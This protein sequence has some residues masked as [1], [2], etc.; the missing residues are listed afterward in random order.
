MYITKNN[1]NFKS[2]N[3]KKILIKHF[4]KKE[5]EDTN[6]KFSLP[7]R[8]KIC[9][10]NNNIFHTFNQYGNIYKLVIFENIYTLYIGIKINLKP[11]IKLSNLVNTYHNNCISYSYFDNNNIHKKEGF[12]ITFFQPRQYDYIIKNSKDGDYILIQEDDEYS[13][14][15]KETGLYIYNYNHNLL[16]N[17][18]Y[19]NY[20]CNHDYSDINYNDYYKSYNTVSNSNF[21]YDDFLYNYKEYEKNN[22][23]LLYE[24]DNN[25]LVYEKENNKLEYEKDNNKLLCE[26]DNNKLLY[27]KDNNELEYEK[28]DNELEYKKEDNELEYEKE[29]NVLEY[30][31]EDNELQYEKE[32]NELEYEKEN[33]DK[34]DDLDMIPK[35]I[36]LIK[37]LNN[38]KIFKN[39]Y[40]FY[41]NRYIKNKL[42]N[43]IKLYIIIIMI[44]IF[45]KQ[46]II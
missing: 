41:M 17:Y 23:Q 6:I 20:Y 2:Y 26:K 22:N 43:N 30:E 19:N 14:Y 24:K 15:E 44:V 1:N 27:E 12:I 33:N 35:S 18:T 42:I 7:L 21:N 3:N 25:E 29:N 31:K 40:F 10:N 46:L 37:N 39:I 11:N 28:K 9:V 45:I 38:I 36:N 4:Y 16:E 8:S 13:E 32:N 34:I 5:F